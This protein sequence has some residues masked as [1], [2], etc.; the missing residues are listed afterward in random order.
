MHRDELS[1]KAK[2]VKGKVKEGLGRATDDERMEQD[3]RAD[4]VEGNVQETVG[5]G[6]RKTREAVDRLTE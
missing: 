3:G 6:K 5:K 1:G 4:Q 2:D